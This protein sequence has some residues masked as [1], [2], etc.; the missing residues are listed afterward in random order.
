MPDDDPFWDAP[1]PAATLKHQLL[2]EY[3]WLFGLKTGSRSAGRRVVYVDGYA[4]RGEYRDGSPGSP[5]IAMRRREDLRSWSSS[6]RLDCLFVEPDADLLPVL[7]TVVGDRARAGTIEQHLDGVLEE[8]HGS[9]LFAFLDPFGTALPLEVIVERILGRPTPGKAFA[10][11]EVL[12]NFSY[13][14]LHRIGGLLH[15]EDPG[16]GAPAALE[17]ADRHFGGP[18]WR[19]LYNKGD[20]T[21]ADRI[22]RRYRRE[23][24]QRSGRFVTW[25]TPVSNRWEGRPVYHL[26]L[27]TAHLQGGYWFGDALSRAVPAYYEAVHGD[28]PTLDAFAPAGLRRDAVDR[29]AGNLR[30]V[31][32]RDG[33]VPLTSTTVLREVLGD[34]YGL[35]GDKELRAAAQRLWQERRL[36]D[37]PVGA[38][39]E[40][41]LRPA[42]QGSLGV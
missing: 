13:T 15:S 23:V 6:R 27:M 17:R 2:H 34:S 19:E 40:L 8:A 35:A 22:A 41:T 7:S 5:R 12:L 24:E 3:L 29:V 38:M 11:T 9:P 32:E 18:W 20:D 21:S 36:E 26:V 25:H 39:Y 31:L 33:Q 1:K 14:A 28:E 42:A 4:G 10:P 37:K 30:R 16:P